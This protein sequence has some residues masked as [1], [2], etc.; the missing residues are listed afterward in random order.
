ML[1]LFTTMIRPEKHFMLKNEKLKVW[2]W[3]LF[4]LIQI[5]AIIC[6]YQTKL[7]ITVVKISLAG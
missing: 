7:V 5:S 3:L 2:S 4:Y 6:I 1:P